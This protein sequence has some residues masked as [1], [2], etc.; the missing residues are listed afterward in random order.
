MPTLRETR[1]RKLMSIATLA[2]AASVA[3]KTIVDIEH[4]RT[5]PRLRTMRAVCDALRVEP[6]EVDE[7]RRAIE[8]ETQDDPDA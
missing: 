5:V 6:G 3:T 4:G 8:G 1:R 2:K 7:F